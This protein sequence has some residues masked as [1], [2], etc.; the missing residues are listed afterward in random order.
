MPGIL[1]S[2][3][4]LYPG[5]CAGRRAAR[6]SEVRDGLGSLLQGTADGPR[7][8]A[9]VAAMLEAAR[10]AGDLSHFKEFI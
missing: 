8:D 1:R 9:G 10:I 3:S 4:P 2:I 7:G 6:G 5:F